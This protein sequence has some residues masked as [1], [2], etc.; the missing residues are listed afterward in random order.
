MYH[1][2][3]T[4][5]S[6]SLYL[7]TSGVIHRVSIY[8]SKCANYSHFSVYCLLTTRDSRDRFGT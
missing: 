5:G 7:P 3:V 8:Y 1:Q 2:F 4:V 6:F